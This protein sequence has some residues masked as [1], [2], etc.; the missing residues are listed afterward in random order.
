MNP[1][2]T[3]ARLF[4]RTPADPYR[5]QFV[6]ITQFQDLQAENA[7][8]RQAVEEFKTRCTIAESEVGLMAKSVDKMRK[9]ID[10]DIACMGRI[11][12]AGFHQ[13]EER[14]QK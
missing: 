10:A 3:I 9:V 6:P 5:P 7:R 12:V 1:F 11:A 4:H 8:L 2:R 13:P 14:R